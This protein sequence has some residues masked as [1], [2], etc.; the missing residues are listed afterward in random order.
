MEEHVA[1][2]RF[3][4]IGTGR[5]GAL[6]RAARSRSRSSQEAL[7]WA[8]DE[9]A[10]VEAIGLGSNLLVHDDGVDALVLKLAG[11]L[12]AVRVDGDDARRGRR[13][14][15]TRC[16]CTARATPG[17]A[18]FEFASAIPGTAGGGVRMNAGAYG[19]ELRDVLVDAR[20]GRRRRRADAD[21][22]RARPRRTATRRSAPGEVVAEVRFRLEPIVARGGQGARS[23]SCSRSARRRS[24][25]TSGR[26]AASSRIRTGEPGAGRMIE[27]CGLKGHRIGGAVDLAA[28][29]E[30]HRERGRRDVG[31]LPRADGRGAPARARAVRRRAR[32]RGALPR[33]ARAARRCRGTP[34]HG[35]LG[36]VAA[37]KRPTARTAALPARRGLPT[38]ARLAALGAL[39]PGRAR[40]RSCSRSAPTSARA[41]RR[42]SRC[43]TLDVRGGTPQTARAGAR[44]ARGRARHAAC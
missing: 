28:P 1:L 27:E 18:G 11:E 38:L 10:R 22:R 29:R 3:T 14:D 41:R 16:A 23:R 37:P 2:A 36:P 15:R 5:P 13:C 42:S 12:A 24:R 30:L 33:P 44:G 34:A 8:A 19:R 32:A 35:E 26:S 9:G 25:R 40:A 20:R 21:A 7:A 6:V 43:E 4:T 31:R 17:S 39:D